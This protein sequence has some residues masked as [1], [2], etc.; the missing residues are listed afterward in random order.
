LSFA[1]VTFGHAQSAPATVAAASSTAAVRS[2]PNCDQVAD[3]VR[4]AI[5]KAPAKLL[6][7]V[8]DF[9]ITN[10]SCACEIVK[11]AVLASHA[12]AELRQQIGVTAIDIAPQQ[13]QIIADCL[14][15]LDIKFHDTENGGGSANTQAAAPSDSDN[16]D[17]TLPLDIRGVFFIEPINGMISTPTTTPPTHSKNP[18]SSPPNQPTPL[19][20]STGP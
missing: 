9:M 15:A 7:T 8:E 17:Y 14:A 10:E 13:K 12:N 16:S 6:P 20:P 3:A 11:A 1:A 2:H 5:A 19:S 18:P 4:E